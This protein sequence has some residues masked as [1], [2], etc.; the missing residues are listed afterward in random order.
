MFTYTDNKD[1]QLNHRV[2]SEFVIPVVVVTERYMLKKK[3]IKIQ[4]VLNV[5]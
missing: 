4:E 1:I 5:S 3:R 2:S